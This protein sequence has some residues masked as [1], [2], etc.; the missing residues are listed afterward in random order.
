M[1]DL[2]T[3]NDFRAYPD[4]RDIARAAANF[5]DVE[6]GHQF[7][8]GVLSHCL[9]TEPEERCTAQ[10]LMEWSEQIRPNISWLYE[11]GERMPGNAWPDAFASYPDS[12]ASPGKVS[13]HASHEARAHTD[14]MSKV[15]GFT[16][17]FCWCPNHQSLSMRHRGPNCPSKQH[18]PNPVVNRRTGLTGEIMIGLEAGHTTG[19]SSTNPIAR[20]E[21]YRADCFIPR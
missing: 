21:S 5:G 6:E 14:A 10:T 13:S 19:E 16:D 2:L 3:W 17:D 4:N 9:A 8:A 20:V 11:Q 1:Y 18:P 15:S 7:M 12:P